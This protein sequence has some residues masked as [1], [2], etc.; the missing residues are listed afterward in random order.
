MVTGWAWMPR[1][2]LR[3]FYR[4]RLY[5]YGF[6]A[7]STSLLVKTAEVLGKID[8]VEEYT[9]LYNNIIHAFRKEFVTPNGRLAVPTQTAHVL[10][11][12]FDLVEEKHRKRVIDTLVE[13][14]R[15][16]DYH[17]TTGFVGTPYLCH[18]LSQNGYSDVA[19][20]LLMQ[21]DYPSW[22][23]QVVKDAT[24]I[25]EHWDGIKPDGSFWSPDMNSFNHYAYGSIGD[26]LYRVVTGID[27]DQEKPGYKH[28][29]IKPVFGEDLTYA[30]A[31]LQSLYGK[32]KSGWKI[33]ED[34]QVQMSIAIPH[35]TTATVV[36]PGARPDL[37]KESGIKLDQAEDIVKYEAV[38]NGVML[39]IGSGEYVFEYT[40]ENM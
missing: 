2:Q 34:G 21:T 36:L 8:D 27:T 40:A 11:L 19:Y 10:A 3:R 37:V 28:I 32:I 24:T 13:Y 4:K 17:L 7:Y 35:N 15:E 12:M 38:D 22:L 31:E 1:R 5:C 23:Y 29:Y 9:K 6:Y 14:I 16:N 30:K 26:W 33:G 39:E 18:V 25:W 20:K